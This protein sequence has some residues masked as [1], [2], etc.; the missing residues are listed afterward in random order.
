MRKE[1]DKEINYLVVVSYREI[2][3]VQNKD[4]KTSYDALH[5]FF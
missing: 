1:I 4:E 3:A 5:Y 2:A